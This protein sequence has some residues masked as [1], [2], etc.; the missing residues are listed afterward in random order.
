MGNNMVALN[1]SL[2]QPPCERD[3]SA[4]TDGRTPPRSPTHPQNLRTADLI[5]A[6]HHTIT[7]PGANAATTKRAKAEL[8]SVL[9]TSDHSLKTD[10]DLG[11][12]FASVLSTVVSVPPDN[13]CSESL[14]EENELRKLTCGYTQR[15]T[16]DRSR[17]FSELSDDY[18]S[19]KTA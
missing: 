15:L 3:D 14:T 8:L 9:A 19:R 6:L 10:L 11:Q 17:P 4:L 5:W 13:S 7:D 12:P 16:D 2:A 1:I 18:A